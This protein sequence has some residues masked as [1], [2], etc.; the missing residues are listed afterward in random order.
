MMFSLNLPPGV[1]ELVA[2]VGG[3]VAFGVLYALAK[4]RFRSGESDVATGI[5][6]LD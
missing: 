5:P 4:R 3:L 6:S 1:G 2:G